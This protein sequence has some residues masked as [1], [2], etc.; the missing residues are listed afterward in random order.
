MTEL[1]FECGDDGVLAVG[2]ELN[3]DNL[4]GFA[5]ALDAAARQASYPL[6]IDLFGLDLDDAPAVICALDA[7]RGLA[8]RGPLTVRYAPHWLA[9]SLYRA[10]ALGA[11]AIRLEEPREEEP[12]G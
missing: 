1:H 2:G 7:L 3:R 12:Y 8:A 5:V 11:E 4:T 10:N 6:V 9:H